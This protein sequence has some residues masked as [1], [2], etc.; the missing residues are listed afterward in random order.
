M[1]MHII[2]D[3]NTGGEA[4]NIKLLFESI[5]RHY[6]HFKSFTG[7]GLKDLQGLA[8]KWLTPG[9]QLPRQLNYTKCLVALLADVVCNAQN[10][11][12]K[13]KTEV[14]LKSYPGMRV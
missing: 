13:K 10:K 9:L 3:R 11:A 6:I 5:L 8:S 2:F 14:G 7:L 1:A 4:F 12:L